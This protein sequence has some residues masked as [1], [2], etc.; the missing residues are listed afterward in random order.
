MKK[1]LLG[2]SG[3]LDSTY[4][5][6]RLREMG[7]YV[8]GAVLKMH[9]YTEIEEA[10][11]SAAYLDVPL[12]VIDAQDAFFNTVVSDFCEAYRNG[13]TPNPCVI[14]NERVKLQRL[15]EEAV[16]SSF[17]YIATGHYARV[18]EKNGRY[19]VWMGEDK[20]KD[21]SYMLYRLSQEVLSRLILPLG[22]LLKADIRAFAQKEG[23]A[24]ANRPESQEIC[25]VREESYPEYIERTCGGLP[26]GDFVDEKGMVLGRHK[27][28]HH[29]TV[30]QRKGLGISAA[31]RL[32]VQS[33]HP[34]DNRIVLSNTPR[35]TDAFYIS[36]LVFSGALEDAFVEEELFE[37][38]IRYLAKKQKARLS[39][40]EDGRWLVRLER[41]AISVTPGQSAVFYRDECVMLGG[42]IEG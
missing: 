38:K 40:E 16:R 34:K 7:Y 20:S 12:R 8:E 13:R 31:S 42:I 21:Q 22:D 15:Y 6:M 14:C 25:F 11:K 23:L 33:I 41:G 2:M 32:F 5:V 18:A 4:A 29:Y 36:S 37:V 17:D 1:V 27:G 3:G 28:I 9:T 26:Q 30:G 35:R 10:E 39:R 24:A 19:A